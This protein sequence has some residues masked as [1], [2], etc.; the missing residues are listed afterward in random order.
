MLI[1]LGGDSISK[2]TIQY[3][4][5]KM[6]VNDGIIINF[7]TIYNGV[8]IGHWLNTQ[9]QKLLKGKLLKSQVLLATKLAIPLT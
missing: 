1:I 2:T 9:R 6:A 8:K 3:E 5:V 7:N 4:I